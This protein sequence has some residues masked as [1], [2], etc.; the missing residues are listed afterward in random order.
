MQLLVEVDVRLVD[1][2]LHDAATALSGPFAP[3]SRW[4]AVGGADLEVDVAQ[5]VGE[6]GRVVAVPADLLG[7]ARPVDR[8]WSP[9]S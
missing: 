8:V 3:M 5:V 4:D 6:V 9:P 7:R 2:G 1:A